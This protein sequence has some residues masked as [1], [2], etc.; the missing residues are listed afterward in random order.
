MGGSIWKGVLP[1]N[2]QLVG[3]K[4]CHIQFINPP[5]SALSVCCYSVILQSLGCCGN[6]WQQQIINS[7]I[8]PLEHKVKTGAVGTLYDKQTK[9][10]QC[11]NCFF[12]IGKGER[13]G[14]ETLLEQSLVCCEHPIQEPWPHKTFHIPL[15]GKREGDE[16]TDRQ[17]RVHD[18]F[19]PLCLYS[20]LKFLYAGVQIL[21]QKHPSLQ[22]QHVHLCHGSTIAVLLP[23][24]DP[25]RS[26]TTQT[27]LLCQSQRAICLPHTAT[28][29]FHSCL[30]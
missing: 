18:N 1:L 4:N 27:L 6:L 2:H 26:S 21:F 25:R 14:D 9:F 19:N 20:L 11:S 23:W 10:P 28:S 8:I 22:L 7:S 24:K 29:I 13:G 17:Q 16:K 3:W 30:R 5:N 15:G 12:P